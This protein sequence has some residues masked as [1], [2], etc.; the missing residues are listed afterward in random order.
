MEYFTEV[1]TLSQS[2]IVHAKL[3]LALIR[4]ILT[5]KDVVAVH[6]LDISTLHSVHSF[7]EDDSG[8]SDAG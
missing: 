5:A 1:Q 7:T 4:I 2:I 3:P 6:Y 8:D